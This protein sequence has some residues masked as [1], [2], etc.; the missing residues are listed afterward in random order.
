VIQPE[1][2][3]ERSF[4]RFGTSPAF[5]PRGLRIL[6]A[7]LS[8]SAVT[9]ASLFAV[10]ATGVSAALAFTVSGALLIG[11]QLVAWR[12]LMIRT[13]RWLLSKNWNDRLRI[14]VYFVVFY[15]VVGLTL[16]F[17]ALIIVATGP[18]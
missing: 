4:G 15:A 3:F 14:V 2:R 11:S 9:F 1:S 7:V 18:Q 6:L 13:Y 16:A 8:A 12:E 17:Y 10:R 5:G